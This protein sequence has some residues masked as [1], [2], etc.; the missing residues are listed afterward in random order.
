MTFTQPRQLLAAALIAAVLG[1]AGSRVGYAN[2]PQ[3]PTLAGASLFLV[4]LVEGGLGVM[5]RPRVQRK[6]GYEPIES[7]TAARAVA[8]AKASSVAGSIM[9]GVWVGLLLYILPMQHVAAAR[10]D[11][12]A[13]VVGVVSAVALIGAG[14]WL[15]YCL[16]TPDE[17]EEPEK[18]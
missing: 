14:L 7:L 12:V 11:T 4:A 6:E 13:A 18:Q 3:L 16:R 17:P 2:L 5:F 1:Y 9:G 15:E 8:L 10:A